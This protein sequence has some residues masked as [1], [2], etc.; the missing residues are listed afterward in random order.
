MTRRLL[1][2]LG[3]LLATTAPLRAQV[4]VFDIRLGAHSAM[5]TGDFA[6]SYDSGFGAYGRVGVPLGLVKLMGSATW[7]RFAPTAAGADDLDFFTLQAGPHFF[8]VP[9]VDLGIEAAYFSDSEKFGLSPNVSVGFLKF[10]LTASYN[11]TLNDPATNWLTIGA[12][13]R[14]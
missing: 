14:F 10:E 5:P 11:T 9:M 13:F 8:L 12:G 7:N 6:E 1:A 4:P 2:A 3:L